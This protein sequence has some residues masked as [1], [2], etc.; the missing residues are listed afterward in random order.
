MLRHTY[1]DQ[2]YS[3]RYK[4][5]RALYNF[6]GGDLA[7]TASVV[8][9]RSPLRSV[10]SRLFRKLKKLLVPF[11][12]STTKI[13]SARRRAARGQKSRADLRSRCDASCA[14]EGLMPIMFITIRVPAHPSGRIAKA[15]LPT[16]FI[17]TT[18]R[19]ELR[20]V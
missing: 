18:P 14:H 17:I 7:A 10:P 13:F 11:G 3:K 9:H 8:R 6:K 19:A 16:T 2:G 20:A 5:L 15:Q 4:G 1:S 12:N